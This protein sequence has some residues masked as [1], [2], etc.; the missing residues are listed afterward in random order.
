MR[1][2]KTAKVQ[3]REANQKCV[4]IPLILQS[5]DSSNPPFCGKMQSSVW[6]AC[7]NALGF[8]IFSLSFSDNA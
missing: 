6:C 5:G 7:K 3:V 4:S 8:D 2:V 1:T